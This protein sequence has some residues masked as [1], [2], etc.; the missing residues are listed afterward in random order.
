[1]FFAS[2]MSRLQPNVCH[3]RFMMLAVWFRSLFK[4]CKC[5][6]QV[7]IIIS[8]Y[9]HYDFLLLSRKTISNESESFV[10]IDPFSDQLDR[11]RSTTSLQLIDGWDDEG[12]DHVESS[13]QPDKSLAVILTPIDQQTRWVWGPELITGPEVW[14]FSFCLDGINLH[15]P[16]TKCLSSNVL[17]YIR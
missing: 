11:Q 8:V 7:K 3:I 6:L 14:I 2:W 16:E 9:F 12:A 17:P 4:K 5:C 15:V 1:M 10:F 13:S